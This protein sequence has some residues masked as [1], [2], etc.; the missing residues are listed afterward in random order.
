MKI[1]FVGCGAAGRPLGRVWRAAGHEIGAVHARAN[2]AAAV[3]AIGAGVADG[4]LEEAEVV[5][6]GTP[7]DAL[8]VVAARTPLAAHQTALHLS[9]FHPSSVLA[10]TGAATAGLH[11]LRA[12]ADVETS[13]AS[14]PGTFFFIEGDAADVAERLARDAGGRPVRMN[15]GSKTLYHAGAAVAANYSV[16]L[17]ALARDLFVGAGVDPEIAL[18]ALGNL[19]LGALRNVQEVGLAPGLTGPAARGDV[20]VV[21]Q[22]IAALDPGARTLYVALLRAT[23][24]IAREKGALTP[25]AEIALRRLVDKHA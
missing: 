12:F 18:E 7:D 11:P 21:A 15:A 5:V 3:E 20:S 9:G 2:A 10:P 25:D 24:P 1:A 14:L 19:A 22:H 4:P 8:Q 16:T 6:F 13:V 17:L 23:I